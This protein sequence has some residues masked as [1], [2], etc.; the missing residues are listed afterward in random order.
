MLISQFNTVLF[1]PPFPPSFHCFNSV[2]GAC[3]SYC[4]GAHGWVARICQPWEQSSSKSWLPIVEAPGCLRHPTSI[5]AMQ[6]L[7]LLPTFAGVLQEKNRMHVSFNKTPT[8]YISVESLINV[9]YEKISITAI[10][11]IGNCQET[12]R[13]ETTE[14]SSIKFIRYRIPQYEQNGYRVLFTRHQSTIGCRA[15]SIFLLVV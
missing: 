2:T 4:V 14:G 8:N 10:F 12:V 7:R 13:R 6:F 11:S 1:P 9:L 15:F 5:L 3:S